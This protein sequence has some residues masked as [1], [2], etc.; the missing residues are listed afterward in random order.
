M[1]FE[2]CHVQNP[3][4]Q[5]SRG[6]FLTGR[7]PSTS[8]LRQNGQCIPE[9]ERTVTRILADNEYI[10]GLSGK[11]HLSA[12]DRRLTLG[13]EWWRSPGEE[14]V[15]Q[16]C[17]R[18][19]DDGYCHTEFHWDH[20]ASA[21]FRSSSYVQWVASQGGSV[22]YTK[23]PDAQQVYDGMPPDLHQ[24]FWC[25]EKAIDFIRR[26]EDYAHPWLFSVNIFDPHFICDPP[27]GYLDRYLEKL[28][29]IPLPNYTPGELENKPEWQLRRHRPDNKKSKAG[30]GGYSDSDLGDPHEHRM[31]R[32]GYWAM[33]DFIDV[34]VGRMLE[35]LEQT[36]QRENTIVIFTSDHGEML[37]DH[38]LYIKGPFLY[39][40]AIHVPLIV[41]QPGVI[42][43]N[44][45][46]STMVELSDL[47]PTLLDA[48]GVEIPKAMQTRS[49]WPVLTGKTDQHREEVY[50]E[51]HNSN[52]DGGRGIYLTMIRT[53]THKL[54]VAHGG[55]G[56]EL[57][58]LEKDPGETHNCWDDP[59]YAQTKMDLLVRLS[60][61]MAY[62]ADPLPER[63]GIY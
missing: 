62:T 39:D 22:G 12:C 28:N 21:K 19:I 1:L 42:P 4:C 45:R 38:G 34:Q 56:G 54:I 60:D 35:A 58:D 31:I 11:L 37:G 48:A 32:A 10:C 61:R 50:C 26:Y 5:P 8:G 13:D 43:Q 55:H 24:T 51:Y 59:D 46:R 25:A 33:C 7:Y 47:A 36:G 44:E 53:Q 17:E 30:M 63:I 23:R 41:S 6:S 16:G 52:P 2:Q 15:V 3:L 49:L 27:P 29:E 18:R 40:E 9:T 20:A 14:Q 57:Y